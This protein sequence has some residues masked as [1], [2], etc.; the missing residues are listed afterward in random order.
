MTS[1]APLSR[2]VA[3]SSAAYVIVVVAL[4]RVSLDTK[5]IDIFIF[6]NV[7]IVS[8]QPPNQHRLGKRMLQSTA[9]APKS[10]SGGDT[11]RSPSSRLCRI[12]RYD[13]STRH[14]F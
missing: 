5:T 8:E 1:T 4:W 2:V 9:D 10:H 11:S 14:P 13:T 12:R 3:C 7:H 6:V